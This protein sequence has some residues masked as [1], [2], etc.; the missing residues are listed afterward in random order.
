VEDKDSVR[1]REGSFHAHE[2]I[3]LS[4]ST[5]KGREIGKIEDV[6]KLPANDIR[7]VRKG[8]VEVLI[9][10]VK[11]IIKNVDLGRQIVVIEE[12][13]GLIDLNAH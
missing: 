3:G 1:P 8:T 11:A 6:W 4:V 9:P 13:E 12:I 5:A 10:A 7:V 2:I